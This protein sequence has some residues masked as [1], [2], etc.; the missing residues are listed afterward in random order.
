M[1]ARSIAWVLALAG[2]FTKPP[3]PNAGNPDCGNGTLD[4]DET[5]DDANLT[6][7]DGCSNACAIEPW[8]TCPSLGQPCHPILAL[9][10][11]VPGTTL[12]ALGNGGGVSF[13]HDCGTLTGINGPNT[14]I[15]GFQGEIEASTMESF[16]G[17]RA[18]CADVT[19]RDDGSI[20]WSDPVAT[21]P[22]GNSGAGGLGLEARM[23]DDDELVTGFDGNSSDTQA[24]GIEL[25]CQ[26]LT[27][28][29]GQLRFGSPNKLPLL[30]PAN[31][32]QRP[33]ASCAAEE[34]ARAFVGRAGAIIDSFSM[35]CASTDL[36]VCGDGNRNEDF[37]TCDDGNAIPGDGCN[38]T[39]SGD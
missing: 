30:G 20:Q 31:Q 23:C 13:D 10:W 8:F 36:V 11:P 1:A 16:F 29:G 39:C 25:R 26:A 3:P 24:A 18:L 32:I 21:T 7:G 4:D 34:V 14:V 22:E 28:T 12:P 37:E 5:C 9:Q 38:E 15:V 2:C 6:A 17:L 33:T 27:H 19:L 35:R